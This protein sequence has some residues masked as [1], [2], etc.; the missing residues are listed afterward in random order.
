MSSNTKPVRVA[1]IGTQ[2]MG[3]VHSHAYKTVAGFLPLK[4]APV[5]AVICGRDAAR[6]QSVAA[7]FG[8]QES[9]ANWKHV[10]ERDDID[11]VD[12]STPGDT[13]CEIALAALKNGKHVICEKPLANTVAEATKMAGAAAKAKV[14]NMC[15]FNYRCVPAVAHAKQMIERGDLGKIY[16]FR[17][18]YLQD[19]ILDPKFP[20]VWRLRKEMAASGPHGD[21]NAHLIDLARYLAGEITEVCGMMETFI[22]NRPLPAGEGELGGAAKKT[23]TKFGEVTVDDAALFL[24]R[25][26]SGALGSFEATRFAAGRKNH[27]TFEINGEKGSLVFD[28]E[29]LNELE[30]YNC[31]DAATERGFRTILCTE[32]GHPYAGYWW[33]AGHMIG[34]E[35][36]FT[37]E[38]WEMLK[39]IESGKVSATPNFSDGL[40]C[41][42]VLEAVQQSV[43]TKK[44]RDVKR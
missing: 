9:S 2:F 19:W 27:N 18:R 37:H 12:I 8:W 15:A 28:L 34:Y 6:T 25:F 40:A 22:K 3:R 7:R 23:T 32:G 31:G 20:L 39:A 44:W 13:H 36:T 14:N 24:A 1:L 29:R 42:R 21:L 35:H 26:E 10:V 11:L 43:D 38:I 41:Q 30:Y 5:M 4:N 16:H 33:P 17:A